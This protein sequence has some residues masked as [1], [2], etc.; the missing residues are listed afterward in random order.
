[1]TWRG[2]TVK[3]TDGCLAIIAD[4]NDMQE[5]REQLYQVKQVIKGIKGGIFSVLKES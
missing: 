4:N 1:M 3:I 5:L 2:V